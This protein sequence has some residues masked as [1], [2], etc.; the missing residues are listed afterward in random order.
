MATPPENGN[1][2]TLTLKG[3]IGIRPFEIKGNRPRQGRRRMGI[4]FP[5]MLPPAIQFV[6]CGGKCKGYF[7][8]LP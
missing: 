6:P 3:S 4:I 8:V 1:G 7:R 2:K 5:G